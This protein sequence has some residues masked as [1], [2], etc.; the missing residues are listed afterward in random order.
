MLIHA[1]ITPDNK[2]SLFIY[3]Q[4]LGMPTSK[5]YVELSLSYIM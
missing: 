4:L 3:L 1:E 2:E 5:N